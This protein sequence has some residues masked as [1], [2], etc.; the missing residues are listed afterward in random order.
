MMRVLNFLI[1]GVLVLA[2][3]YVYK[4]KFNSTLRVERAAKLRMEIRREHDVIARLR[5][6]W[7]KLETPGRIQALAER[8]LTLKPVTSFQFQSFAKLP[9]RPPQAAQS[10]EDPIGGLIGLEDTTGSIPA[11]VPEWAR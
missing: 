10:S 7:A 3:S 11:T 1:I 5:T 8:H 4:I 9:E 2:A 6:E